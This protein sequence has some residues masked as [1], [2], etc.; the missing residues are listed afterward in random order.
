[1]QTCITGLTCLSY[2]LV[3][4]TDIVANCL[5]IVKPYVQLNKHW[6][7]QDIVFNHNSEPA[8]TGDVSRYID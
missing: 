4:S 5:S 3:K 1:V 2:Q 8:R 7:N 6:I